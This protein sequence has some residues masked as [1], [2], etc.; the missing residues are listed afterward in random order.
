M[1]KGITGETTKL[2]KS[3][4]V[5]YTFSGVAFCFCQLIPTF[6]VYYAT[7]SLL[8]SIGSVTLMM[9]LVK[10][11][12]GVTDIVAGIIIDKT[13][14]PKGK[15]RPW[16]LRAAVPYA[17]CMVLMF[18]IPKSLGQVSKLL[19]LAVLYALTVSV[20][21]TLIGVARITLI[22]RMTPDA[23]ERGM[24]GALADGVACVVLGITMAA[25]MQLSAAIGWTGTFT[26]FGI[27]AFAACLICYGLTRERTEEINEELEN[28]NNNQKVEIKTLFKVLF[29]NKY[30]LLLLI[31]ILLQQIAGGTITAEG[32]YYFQYVCGDLN[33]FSQMMVITVVAA[34]IA[35]VAMPFLAKKLG[36]K[37]MFFS[38]CV[39]TVICYIIMIAAGKNVIVLMVSLALSQVFGQ[40]FIMTQAGPLAAAV[41]DYSYDKTGVHAEGIISSIVNIGLKIGAALA[42][43]IMGLILSKGGFVEGAVTQPESAVQALYISYMI[44][45]LVVFAVLAIF[46]VTT[47]KLDKYVPQRKA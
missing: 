7:Q 40:M 10:V 18:S 42:T 5:G 14:T 12:D 22:S 30:A 6:L 38:G 37:K 3:Q 45:P 35:A 23:S 25:G 34:I 41:S 16:I 8:I 15:A 43:G 44:V 46:F 28:Q 24:L 39:L 2:P 13:N 17:V 32:A 21:G 33:G 36:S 26:L 20:F 9:M 27:I 1:G 29:T 4:K 47:Y 19:L 31:Y 11:F